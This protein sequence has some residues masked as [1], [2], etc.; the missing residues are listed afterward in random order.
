MIYP[1]FVY[2][3]FV[4]PLFVYP[5]FDYPALVVVPILLWKYCR[6]LQNGVYKAIPLNFQNMFILRI[7]IPWSFDIPCC[8]FK[9]NDFIFKLVAPNPEIENVIVRFILCWKKNIDKGNLSIFLDLRPSFSILALWNPDGGFFCNIWLINWD[10]SGLPF[11]CL[12]YLSTSVFKTK[13][14]LGLESELYIWERASHR[15]TRSYN[16]FTQYFYKGGDSSCCN[17]KLYR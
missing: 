4:Y 6:N 17:Q 1:A 13:Y 14:N 11:Q 16:W 5:A 12:R 7:I 9:R 8:L 15:Q 3:L 2:P 10:Y